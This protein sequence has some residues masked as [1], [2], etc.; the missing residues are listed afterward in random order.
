M[1]RY[2]RVGSYQTQWPPQ[3]GVPTCTR[4][5]RLRTNSSSKHT[6]RV[7]M[8]THFVTGEQPSAFAYRRFGQVALGLY[9]LGGS[10]AP[11]ARRKAAQRLCS[12]VVLSVCERER[13]Y[14][15]LSPG[16]SAPSV[17]T[18]FVFHLGWRRVIHAYFIF[19][20]GHRTH[21]VKYTVFH[22]H[23]CGAATSSREGSP[24][25]DHFI[26]YPPAS[27]HADH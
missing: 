21:S 23:K 22:I 10:G 13:T 16:H 6:G 15:G 11:A 1:T 3:G 20:I 26:T 2:H 25:L 12:C 8:D 4:Q 9:S 24:I 18:Y 19:H 5:H 14:I 27:F 7:V 17:V